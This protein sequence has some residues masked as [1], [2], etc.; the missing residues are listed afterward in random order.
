MYLVSEGDTD[1]CGRLPIPC[2]TC[3]CCGRGMVPARGWTWVKADEIIRAT[4]KKCK[5]ANTKQCAELCVINQVIIGSETL[6]LAGLIW[7]GQKHYPTTGHFDKEADSIGVSRRINFIPKEFKLGETYV[8]LAHQK[9][10]VEGDV[11]MGAELVFKP[12]I[13]RIFKPDAIEIV[14]NGEESDEV[15]DGYVK[16]GLTP[17]MIERVEDTQ[18]RMLDA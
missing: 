17:V 1:G 14:V 3:P 5:F 16:R 8:L 7:V 18:E 6:G 13:F 9:A 11:A 4:T 12:G 10:I 15:I 2:E